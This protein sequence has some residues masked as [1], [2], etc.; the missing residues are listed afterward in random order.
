MWEVAVR[1]ALVL[2]LVAVSALV[3]SM[4]APVAL[5]GMTA[6]WSAPPGVD[7]PSPNGP[8]PDGSSPP[9][10]AAIADIPSVMLALYQSA[11]TRCPGL[12]WE[13]LAGIGKVETNH[14]RGSLLSPA[15][16]EGPMQ[17]MPATW[18]EYGVDADGDGDPSV[19]DPADAVPAAADL[20]CANG[21]RDPSTLASAIFQYNHDA[22]YVQSVLAWA[23]RYAG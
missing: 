20:L 23:A 14:G 12:P 21:G 7:A 19:W 8:S 22:S 17:F 11:A 3:V 2:V 13:V 15:G 9:S 1:I 16:A 18:A 6:S 10:A 5:A 4:A